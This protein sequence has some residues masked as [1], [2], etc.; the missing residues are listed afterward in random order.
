MK[1]DYNYQTTGSSN[2]RRVSLI[3]LSL[4]LLLFIHPCTSNIDNTGTA[5]FQSYYINNT[6]TIPRPYEA[7]HDIAPSLALTYVQH[8]NNEKK[9]CSD[10]TSSSP[11]PTPIVINDKEPIQHTRRL[12]HFTVDRKIH[13]I[14]RDNNDNGQFE[15]TYTLKSHSDYNDGTIELRY[16]EFTAPMELTGQIIMADGY[17]CWT[18]SREMDL[19]GRLP[20]ISKTVAWWT[21]FNLQGDYDFFDYSGVPG[22]IHSNSYTYLRDEQET[23]FIGSISEDSGYTYFKADYNT[24][25][26]RIYK[27][28]DGLILA[29]GETLTLR[30][31]ITRVPEQ[32]MIEGNDNNNQD[33]KKSVMDILWQR[34]AA[35]Y[36]DQTSYQ[37]RHLTG[38]TS[39]YNYY[40]RVTEA[41]VIKSLQGFIYHKYPIDVFQI[42]DG[43][44][45]AIGDWLDINT[46]KFPRGMHYLSNMIEEAGF[47]PG[48]WVAPFAVGFKSRIVKEHP[49]WLIKN[50]DGSN[51]V[52][53]PNWGGFYALDMYHPEARGYLRHVFDTILHDWG[54]KLLKLDFIFAA[55]MI[56]R[57]G[58]S[59]G[60]LL[61][62]ACELIDE[63]TNKRAIILG[64]GV[65]L[66]ATWHRFEYNR[67][68]S[69]ASPFWD[70]SLL[71]LANVRE[72]VSTMNALTSTLHRWPMKHMFGVDPD[73]FFL[74]SNDNK[75]SP[76]ECYAS[77]MINSIIGHLTLMSDD[78]T[79]Y[80]A[81]RHQL[82]ASTFP[83]IKPNIQRMIPIGPNA[84]RIDFFANQRQYITLV[85]LSP[86][87]FSAENLLGDIHYVSTS[88]NNNIISSS[89]SSKNDP[90][91]YFY[92]HKNILTAT[93]DKQDEW[94]RRNASLTLKPHEAR[95]FTKLIDRFGGSSGHIVPGWEIDSW[96]D[97][98]T[99]SKENSIHVHLRQGRM[100]HPFTLFIRL[101]PHQ[102]EL[103][104]VFVD[105]QPIK[106]QEYPVEM[107][108][109]RL[110]KISIEA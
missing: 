31:M 8:K 3:L 40:E 69:D 55:A 45:Q 48:L 90:I 61:W 5:F 79:Q 82:Y 1:L 28:V 101:H 67:V 65:P 105:N 68:S 38:W 60:Q 100:P 109:L 99:S 84:Y 21:W 103:P 97:R 29:N 39:W 104:A 22:E 24:N 80:D 59:R 54:Y 16:L 95:I 83:K 96:E 91:D 44:Q 102:Q 26:F 110:A 98:K 47:I 74:R 53:G 34:Y 70:H 15:L 49:D 6:M 36:T 64:S 62:E 25:H 56:P 63:L 11:P 46:D 9:G 52:A 43:Y 78:L 32:Q 37:P 107:D 85:N 19:N 92:E 13:D 27:D 20:P 108:D 12:Q 81:K 51:L 106:V 88:S 23:V 89:S 30:F 94:I 75:L 66:A 73:V 41:D 35:Y 4:F 72:R 10:D 93:P 50:K 58:K 71:R 18:H 76:E 7:L 86:L 33:D 42:D 17:Q 77:C 2:S 87:P 57:H 14:H